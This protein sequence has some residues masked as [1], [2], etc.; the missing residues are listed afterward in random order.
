MGHAASDLLTASTLETMDVDHDDIPQVRDAA[1][2]Q[3]LGTLAHEAG[4]ID[5]VEVEFFAFA[6]QHKGTNLQKAA[7]GRFR[8]V[9]G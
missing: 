3:H 8:A 7:L 9:L 1:I 5:F 6:R 2:A 4:G